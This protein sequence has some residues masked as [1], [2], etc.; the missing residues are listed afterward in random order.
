IFNATT[1]LFGAL[2]AWLWLRDRLTGARVLGLVIGFAGVLWLAWNN[3]NQEASFRPGGSGLAVLA[4][5]AAA[6]LYGLSASYTK[7][8]LAGVAPLAVATGSQLSATLVLSPLAMVW[9]PAAAPSS[10]AWI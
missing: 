3:V 8:R 7:R 5:L 9:W 6:A 2:V 4:C 1:P 10:S